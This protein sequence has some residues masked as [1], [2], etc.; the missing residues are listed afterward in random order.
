MKKYKIIYSDPPWKFKKG[1]W[2]RPQSKAVSH[3]PLMSLE[4][5]YSLPV[6]RLADDNAHLYL[7]IPSQQLL[8]GI[9]T[10]VCEAWGFRAMNVLTW[11]KPQ[12]GLGNYFRNNTEHLIF[13]VRGKFRT[14]DRRQGTWFIADRQKH[15]RK[16]ADIR[17]MIVRCWSGDLPRLEIFSRDRIKGWTSVGNEID[18]KDVRESLLAL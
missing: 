11:C 8:A 18:G 9:G 1:L 17:D 12:I 6:E 4:D 5:I 7:W 14:L 16:P 15:S 13:A 2:Q 10:K 3:Y